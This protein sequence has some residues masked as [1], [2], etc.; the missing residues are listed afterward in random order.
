MFEPSSIS[1][2]PITE[3]ISVDLQE[4]SDLNYSMLHNRRPLFDKFLIRVKKPGTLRDVRLRV[5]LSTG[6]ET[7]HYDR[8]LDVTYPFVDVNQAIHVPLTS[9]I[10]R[11][12]RE[13]VRTSLFIEVLWGDRLV[14]RDTKR[15]RLTPVDQWRDS[16]DDRKWLPSF[17]FPRDPAVTRLVDL[18][19]RYVRTLRDDPAAGFDGYQSINI[20]QKKTLTAVDLQVQAIWSAIVHEMRLGYIN[21]PPSYS[22]DLDLQR[23]R[24]PWMIERDHSGTC[25]DLALFFAA[26]LELVDIYPVIFLLEG[27]AFPGYWRASE[28]HEE[29]REARPEGIREI[30]RATAEATGVFGAQREPW[31][32]GKPTYREIV[33]FVN[34]EKLVP[35]ESARLTE[36]SGFAEAIGAGREN[37]DTAREFHSM[38]DIAIAREEQVTPLPILGEQS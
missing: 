1:T 16:D 21:P 15:V 13:S 18:A 6:N 32:L 4:C 33:Q 17:I 12:V 10:T 23:L 37:L 27:H 9:S 2:K 38:I 24:T 14:Y 19:Q 30:V 7:A 8:L 26:C 35:I 36:Y 25:I 20:N 28:Y 29:F 11:S 5:S 3:W 31:Y 34:A 22:S